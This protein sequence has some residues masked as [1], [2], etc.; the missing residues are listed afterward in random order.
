M[1]GKRNERKGKKMRRKEIEKGQ[2]RGSAGVEKG[3]DGKVKKRV[4]KG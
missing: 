3:R 1:E 2:R 4:R